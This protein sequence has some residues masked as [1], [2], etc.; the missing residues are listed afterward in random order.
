MK[1]SDL[2]IALILSSVTFVL[3]VIRGPRSDP[4]HGALG[5]SLRSG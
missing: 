3:D 1:R 5:P 2:I 4:E